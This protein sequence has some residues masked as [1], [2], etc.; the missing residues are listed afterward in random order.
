[1]ESNRKTKTSKLKSLFR[2]R[3]NQASVGAVN[4][5]TQPEET[6]PPTVPADYGDRERTEERYT[7][8]YKLLQ[9]AVQN[10]QH[11]AWDSFE[12]K[13]LSGEPKEFDDALFKSKI[14]AALESRRKAIKDQ[15]LCT[16]TKQIIESIY[17][18]LSPFAQNFLRIAS[19]AQ[20]VCSTI[21]L[22]D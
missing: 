16:K 13:E 22:A 9:N 17:T 18:S 20:S 19:N 8:A 11:R 6:V 12:F 1:M 14:H 10:R 21:K 15:S 3:E 2:R 7:E 4:V 5:V